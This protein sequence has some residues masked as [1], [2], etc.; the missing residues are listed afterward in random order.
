VSARA[1]PAFS[2]LPSRINRKM[3]DVKVEESG[4]DVCDLDDEKI[5]NF[6]PILINDADASQHTATTVS[7][8]M[9]S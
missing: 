7:A 4:T 6:A 1:L 2:K 8:L 3:W 9:E 5:E